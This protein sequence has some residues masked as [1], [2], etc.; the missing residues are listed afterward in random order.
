MK[1]RIGI[2]HSPRELVVET[3]TPTDEVLSA[4]TDAVDHG[5]SV[6]L[7]DKKGGT[8]LIPGGKVAYAEISD[9]E[10]RRVGFLG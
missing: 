4:L 7:K 10:P 9:E 1:I 8:L 6:T 3:D 5:T 2:Q